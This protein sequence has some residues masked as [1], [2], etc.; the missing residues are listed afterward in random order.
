VAEAP[1]Q[2]VVGDRAAIYQQQPDLYA[3]RN[4][5]AADAVAVVT[6]TES[7]RFLVYKHGAARGAGS[8]SR[9]PVYAAGQ[10][11]PLAIP[12]GRVLVRLDEGTDAN[13]YGDRFRAAGFEIDRVLS[14]APHAAWLR[15][16]G[17]NVADALGSL[18][19]LARLPGV[20]HVE[21]QLLL[22]RAEK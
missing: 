11:G 15:P 8:P 4:G 2:L 14:Y 5:D 12:T 21:P 19:A 16:Q 13:T 3:I 7:D 6:D 9:L 22:D 18:D 17:G 20:V 1:K 10:G